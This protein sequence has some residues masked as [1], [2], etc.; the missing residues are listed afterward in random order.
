LGNRAALSREFDVGE[1]S[2]FDHEINNDFVA[3]QGVE[4]LD[5]YGG[6][7]RQFATITRRTVV[8]EDHFA[9]EVFEV[10]HVLSKELDGGGERLE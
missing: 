2:V 4:T 8:V 6:W 5:A 7:R 1:H 3:A 10:R 9:V